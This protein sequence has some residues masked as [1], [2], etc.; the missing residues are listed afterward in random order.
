MATNLKSSAVR[1]HPGDSKRK[2]LHWAEKVSGGVTSAP[3]VI[4]SIKNSTLS[5]EYWRETICPFHA[6]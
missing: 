5:P 2:A 6:I 4:G 3:F 1:R